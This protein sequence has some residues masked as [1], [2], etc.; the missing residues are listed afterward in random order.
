LKVKRKVEGSEEWKRR[1]EEEGGES[2]SKMG[3]LVNRVCLHRKPRKMTV[4]GCDDT[5]RSPYFIDRLV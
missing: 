2:L 4:P 3:K 1:K 5:V